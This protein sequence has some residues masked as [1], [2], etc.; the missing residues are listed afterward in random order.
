MTRLDN[1]FPDYLQ[2]KSKQGTGNYRRNVDRVVGK[3]LAFLADR[4]VETFDA[5]KPRHL[6]QYA[7]HL[8]R[9]VAAKDNF[10]GASA[11]KY[12][13][14]VRAYLTWCTERGYLDSNPAKHDDAIDSL[15]DASSRSSHRQQF[16]SPD[17]RQAI[18]T[19]VNE[20]AHDAV[21]AADD[22][23]DAEPEIRDRAFVAVIAYTGARG[24]E[25]LRDRNDARRDG[26][27]WQDVNLDAGTMMVLGKGTQERE[28]T[29]I[30]RQAVG[31]LER[32]RDLVDPPTPD[33][34]VFPTYHR[35]TLA[36]RARDALAEAAGAASYDEA[37]DDVQARV[38][39]ALG[40]AESPIAVL[41][42]ERVAPPSITTAGAR[43]LMQR[44]CEA[45]DIPEIDTDAG[46]YLELH[47][48]RRGAGTTVI[49]EKGWEHGQ[50]LLRHASP[51]TTMESYSDL[52]TKE[53]TEDASEAFEEADGENS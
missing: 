5:L 51:E 23:R 39:D 3:F 30:P 13:H 28:K 14:Y 34:P 12:Y 21:D 1:P 16:W 27:R 33:W 18:M 31:L 40:E 47:G 35:P 44:L 45:A 20:R 8:G 48:G 52:A 41:R 9:R 19:Y 36:A 7:L 29:G 49:R 26:L 10:S 17:Q 50:E 25:V 53:V 37:S 15:P 2:Q 38:D 24:G 32:L 42:G 46:E 11:E 43:N 4:D 22:I 6:E